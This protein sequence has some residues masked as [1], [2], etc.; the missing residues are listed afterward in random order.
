MR[1]IFAAIAER[2]AENQAGAVATLVAAHDATPAPLGT[3]LLVTPDGS[4]LGNIG[5]GCHE[6]A[7]IEAAQ[8]ALRDGTSSAIAFDLKDEVLDGSVCGAR[9]EVVVWVPDAT[10]LQTAA[11]IAAGRQH[12]HFALLTFQVEIPHKKHLVIVGATSLAAE[13]VLF[14]KRLDFRTTVIDPRPPFATQLRHPFADELL[15]QWPQEALP[16]LLNSETS[17]VIVAHDAKIDLPAIRC[18]LQSPAPYIGVIG[19]RRTQAM[20]RKVLAAEGYDAQSLDR[21]HGPAGL[22]LGGAAN[23]EIAL[24]ILAEIT[25]IENARSARPLRTTEGRIHG[26]L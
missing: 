13:L 24:S 26:D 23:G 16:A 6:G 25:A 14:A 21:L 5:A 17:A 22:D 18:A 1:E 3:S 19:N 8:T 12:V 4:F 10:F 15:V 7:I 9:L 2:I 11:Q 20:R